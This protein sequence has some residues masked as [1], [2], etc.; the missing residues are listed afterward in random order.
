ML[1]WKIAWRNLVRHRGK[2][3]VIGVILFF[4]AFMMTVGNAVIEGAK[5]GLDEN[6]VKRFTGHLLL[7]S[8]DEKKSSVLFTDKALAVISDYPAVKQVLEQQDV[9]ADFLPL[10][11]GIAMIPN[12]SGAPDE[13]L[14]LGVNFEDYQQMFQGN[15]RALEGR[16]LKNMER[17]FLLSAADRKKLHKHQKFWVLPEGESL[18]K[19]RLPE[20]LAGQAKHM[21]TRSELVFMGFG[22]DALEADIRLPVKGIIEFQTLD[23]VWE[24]ISFMD[25][26]SFRQCFGYITAADNAVEIP[27]ERQALLAA[28]NEDD[29]FGEASMIQEAGPETATY[30]AGTL[31]H[32]TERVEVDRVDVDIDNGAYNL[33]AVKFQ[34]GVKG[35]EAIERLRTALDVAQAGVKVL[36]WQQ[37]SGEVAQFAT[38]TQYALSVFVLFLF[39]VAII[40]IM[41][42][43]SMAALERTAEI[44]MMRA[45]G[46]KKSMISG[47][48]VMETVILS[49]VFGGIGMAA[50]ILTAWGVG[51][52]NISITHNDILSLLFGG[53]TF[54]PIVEFAGVLSGV[55]QLAIVTLLAILYPVFVARRITPLQAI[56][57]D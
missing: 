51:A 41:N 25:I 46:A 53:D 50:G 24:G 42:T 44:G 13:T 7:A 17:G 54:R 19:S 29:F 21:D 57:R 32:Q 40:V 30:D 16:L 43:L 39:F 37:A 28:D 34:D 56:S 2:S 49:A 26:E 48:F 36:T 27:E 3:L 31:Q 11:R 47:M 33:V 23:K 9:V 10:A 38:M 8:A 12:E 35:A 18:D 14:V 55:Q 4:G 1:T 15:V 45:I 22:A 6:M 5:Q 52:L 20:E